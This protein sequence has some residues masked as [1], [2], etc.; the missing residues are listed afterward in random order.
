MAMM[1]EKQKKFKFKIN[2]D[3]EILQDGDQDK[4]NLDAL[5]DYEENE[6]N[7]AMCRD[8]GDTNNPLVYMS[9]ISHS[10]ILKST[11]EST[12]LY[13]PF[14]HSTYFSCGHLI[15][16]KCMYKYKQCIKKRVEVIP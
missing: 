4:T 6:V 16:M 3:L 5:Q 14:S 9:L 1:K 12:Y 15:H 11:A 7:C 2:K 13:F 8:F 10:N